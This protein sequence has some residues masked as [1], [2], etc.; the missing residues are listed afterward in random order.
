MQ[1]KSKGKQN[2]ETKILKEEVDG[3]LESRIG[4]H[5]FLP[6]WGRRLDFQ[7]HVWKQEEHMV[8]CATRGAVRGK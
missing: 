4:K 7:P 5:T 2:E 1:N 6:L 3:E 8:F